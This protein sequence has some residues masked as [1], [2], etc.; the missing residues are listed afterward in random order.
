MCHELLK[1]SSLK[2]NN[3]EKTD[4]AHPAIYPT[5]VAPASLKPN[6]RKIYDLVV[7]RFMATFAK[8]AIR[9]TMEVILDVKQELFETKGTRTVEENWHLFYKPYVKLE[10]VTLPEMKEADKIKITEIKKLDKETQPPKRYN[11]S[12]IIKELEKRNLGTKATRAD[13]LDRLFQRGYLEGVQITVTQIGIQTTEILEKYAPTIVDDQLTAD[14]ET[15]MDK[16]REGKE[17]PEKVLE[18]AKEL[19]IKLL[20]DFKKKEK[21]IGKDI[22]QSVR[23]TQDQT[24]YVGKCPRCENGKL[25][26]RRGKFGAFIACNEYPKCEATFKLPTHGIVKRSEKLCESCQY[27]MISVLMHRMKKEMCINPNCPTKTSSAEM[28]EIK[29]IEQNKSDRNCPKCGSNL[30]VRSSM[31]GRFLGCSGYP[32][33]KHVEKIAPDAPPAPGEA[34]PEKPIITIN[35]PG[36]SNPVAEPKAAKPVKAKVVKKIAKK[37]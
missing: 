2:P 22:I 19:L 5:G 16:I 34:T 3:G 8:A 7:K 12:S 21:Q 6:E 36:E 20:T 14:F 28:K 25:M 35:I 1:L 18:R 23:N 15:E 11:Q 33:C 27:P 24:N 26:M 4:P 30:I 37:K 17:K 32:K 31:Y 9:E 13:I 29:K 10:E